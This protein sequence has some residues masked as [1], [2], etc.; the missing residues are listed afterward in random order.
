MRPPSASRIRRRFQRLSRIRG[1]VLHALRTL[2]PLDALLHPVRL[3]CLIHAA[4]V[5]S[6]PGSN[7]PLQ[8]SPTCDSGSTF[9][10][11]GRR[12]G[13]P[14]Y[15]GRGRATRPRPAHRIALF[16]FQGGDPAARGAVS[17]AGVTG[18]GLNMMPLSGIASRSV[19]FRMKFG[20]SGGFWQVPAPAREPPC[21]AIR[22]A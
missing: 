17:N 6:E 14:M 18:A 9:L 19:H 3:A 8:K 21:R 7:S 5:H 12:L 1:Q 11:A 4:S 16:R 13:R 15:Y 10:K 20:V 2:S 22:A